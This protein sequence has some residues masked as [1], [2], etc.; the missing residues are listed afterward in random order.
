[1]TVGRVLAQ[2]AVSIT[3]EASRSIRF[4]SRSRPRPGRTAFLPQ[5]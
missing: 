1:M 3:R 4:Q 5:R 2:D